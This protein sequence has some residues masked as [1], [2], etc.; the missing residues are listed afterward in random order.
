[1][2]APTAAMTEQ[3]R[4][5]PTMNGLDLAKAQVQLGRTLDFDPKTE[6]FPKDAEANALLRR[7]YRKPF[8]VPEQA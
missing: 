4:S 1:M 7:E 2:N 6:T 3:D 8:A 5:A